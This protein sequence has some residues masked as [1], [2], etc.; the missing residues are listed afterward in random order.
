VS[1]LFKVVLAISLKKL[2]KGELGELQLIRN[3]KNRNHQKFLVV[4]V[5]Y[6]SNSPWLLRN[7]KCPKWNC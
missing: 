7:L 6:V 5:L 2:F 1:Q 4:S 3:I